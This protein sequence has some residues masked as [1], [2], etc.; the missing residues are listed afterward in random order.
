MDVYNLILPVDVCGQRNNSVFS[1]RPR[2]HNR[3]LSLFVFVILANCWKTVFL[4]ERVV[5]F[6]EL[7]SHVAQAGPEIM[8]LL[9]PPP[10]CWVYICEPLSPVVPRIFEESIGMPCRWQTG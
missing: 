6:Y 7:G 9:S 5:W 10:K 1:E 8:I 4:A 3:R 2:E